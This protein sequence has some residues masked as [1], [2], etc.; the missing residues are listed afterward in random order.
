LYAIPLP[1]R[2]RAPPK[3]LGTT[4]NGSRRV[5]LILAVG[6]A[7]ATATALH[8]PLHAQSVSGRVL[9]ADNG[10]PVSQA[11]IAVIYEGST[12]SGAL[13][14]DDGTFE[15]SL[16]RA[17]TYTLRVTRQGYVAQSVEEVQVGA[18]EQATVPDVALEPSPVILDEIRV[19]PRLGRLRPG[20]ERVRQRQLLGEGTF[21]SGALIEQQNPR[22][23]TEYLAQHGGFMVRYTNQGEPYLWSLRG[24]YNCLVV[25]VNHWPLRRSGFRTLDEIPLHWIAAVEIYPTY[26][27]VPPEGPLVAD[28]EIGAGNRCGLLNVWLWNSW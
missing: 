22:S 16:D 2:K 17:G 24:P 1:S 7:L 4:M 19:E 11:T 3:A 23:L 27:E 13:T 6:I 26:R 14:G 28:I 9:D 12:V 8:A 25:Q 5:R 20:R 21:L 15:I 10:A 18:G